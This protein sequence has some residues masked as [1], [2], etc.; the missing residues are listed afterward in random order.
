LTL[1]QTEFLPFDKELVC[2]LLFLGEQEFANLITWVK[3]VD[4]TLMPWSIINQ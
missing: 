4:I 1:F 3:G 2:L